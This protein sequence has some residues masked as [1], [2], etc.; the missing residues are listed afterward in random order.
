MPVYAAL[1]G[2]SA[3]HDGAHA[4]DVA[5]AVIPD[6]TI[7]LRP[8]ATHSLPMEQTETLGRAILEFM[9]THDS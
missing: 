2:R 7:E 8:D 9:G 6:A 1:A 3:M 4:A 5:R